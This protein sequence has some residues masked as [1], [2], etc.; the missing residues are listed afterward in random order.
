MNTNWI[1]ALIFSIAPLLAQGEVAPR[2]GEGAPPEWRQRLEQAQQSLRQAREG[3]Q[4]LMQEREGER[5]TPQRDRAP[6]QQDERGERQGRGDGPGRGE[7]QGRSDGRRPQGP[8]A[9]MQ[10][11]GERHGRGEI[12][13][14]G[15][16]HGRGDGRRPQGPGARM[17]R[18]GAPMRGMAPMPWQGRGEAGFGRSARGP[19]VER[20]QQMQQLRERAMQWRQRMGDGP[21]TGPMRRPMPQPQGRGRSDV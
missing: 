2:A 13:G 1:A 11:G 18:G 5:P 15:E 9:R 20:L 19:M 12:Q 16:R 3:V 4:R 17:Q 10:R 21:R 6:R 7:R 14:R 8:G